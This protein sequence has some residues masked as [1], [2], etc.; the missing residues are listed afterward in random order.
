MSEIFTLKPMT[1]MNNSGEA[2]AEFIKEQN[3]QMNKL[4]HF[5][6][7]PFSCVGTGSASRRAGW[8]SDRIEI[9]KDFT[10]KS[11]LGQTNKNFILWVSFRP[12]DAGNKF[13]GELDAFLRRFSI[14][15]VFTF[16]GLM[17]HDDKFNDD[18][19][20]IFYNALR[21][22]RRC[23]RNGEW[24]GVVSDIR[25]LFSGKNKTLLERLKSSLDF[26]KPYVSDSYLVYLTRLDSD[27]MLHKDAI[28]KIQDAPLCE[29]VRIQ[30][31]YVY[32]TNSD[33]MAEWNPKTNPPF[34]TLIMPSTIFWN[35]GE[36]LKWYRGFKSHEDIPK[37]FDCEVLDERLYCVLTHD[38]KNHISTF[39][40]HPF[41]G[42]M[43]DKSLLKSFVDLDAPKW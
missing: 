27:D 1:G 10:L 3:K 32:D 17:Y 37:L 15:F 13:I 43:V 25:E 33:K 18:W 28:Q 9:F 31:G 11:L 7:V 40:D 21:I 41:R 30:N 38:P 35:A 12:E 20:S 22:L 23:W 6:Y 39:F 36:H 5:V 14:N 24:K 16:N 42:E 2:V 26:I 8:L 4:L 34:H 29:A 19:K